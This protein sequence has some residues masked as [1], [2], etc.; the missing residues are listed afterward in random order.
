MFR[1]SQVNGLGYHISDIRKGW[2]FFCL[3]VCFL[4]CVLSVCFVV[5]VFLFVFCLFV[6]LKTIALTI[7]KGVEMLQKMFT[8][9]KDTEQERPVQT[10]KTQYVYAR[11]WQPN[12]VEPC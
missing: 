3:F 12:F 8:G 7:N 2:G 5:V 1:I 11:C 10:E 6:C 9:P 4:F